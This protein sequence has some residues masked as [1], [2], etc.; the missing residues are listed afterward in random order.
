LVTREHEPRTD[1]GDDPVPHR[2][3]GLLALKR[4]GRDADAFRRPPD[5]RVA[6]LFPRIW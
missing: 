3:F 5:L 6:G 4:L 1:C 2:V